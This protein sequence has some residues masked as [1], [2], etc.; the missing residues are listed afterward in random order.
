MNK[1]ECIKCLL[2][3]CSVRTMASHK[4]AQT[5]IISAT[6]K[7]TVASRQPSAISRQ[8]SA[9]SRQ[10]SDLSRAPS[11]KGTSPFVRVVYA[12]NAVK[13]LAKKQRSNLSMNSI[14]S[15][16]TH[17]TLGPGSGMENYDCPTPTIPNKL[18]LEHSQKTLENVQQT[19]SNATDQIN[20]TINANLS[21]LRTLENKMLTK[22]QMLDEY[23]NLMQ[24]DANNNDEII[25]IHGHESGTDKIRIDMQ[26]QNPDYVDDNNSNQMGSR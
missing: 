13:T 15:D 14:K 26:L 11:S 19:V 7:P 20:K 22:S 1:N 18:L 10:A 25:T 17:I 2:F 8:T 4:V 3:Q 12:K 6:K 9:M 21:D 16:A 23:R 24:Q 5:R